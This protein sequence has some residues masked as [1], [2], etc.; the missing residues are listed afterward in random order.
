MSHWW[1]TDWERPALLTHLTRW[2]LLSMLFPTTLHLLSAP[3]TVF[4]LLYLQLLLSVS[5]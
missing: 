5:A 1:Q 2:L 4:W 3:T